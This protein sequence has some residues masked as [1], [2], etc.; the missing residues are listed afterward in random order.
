MTA[1]AQYAGPSTAANSNG[2]PELFGERL[3]RIR[4]SRGFSRQQL[5][6]AMGVTVAAVCLLEN[7]QSKSMRVAHAILAAELL[8]VS[9]GDLVFGPQAARDL[10]LSAPGRRLVR[11]GR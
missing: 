8:R 5:A 6:N 7:G 11:F 10:P 1:R 2:A 9:C 3:K 4:I